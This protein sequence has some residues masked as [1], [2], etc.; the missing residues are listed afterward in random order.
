MDLAP[1]HGTLF[2]DFPFVFPFC[3]PLIGPKLLSCYLTLMNTL[4]AL[5]TYSFTK[6]EIYS[7]VRHREILSNVMSKACRVL[8]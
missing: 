8:E 6:K 2:L 7:E 1:F 5:L 3:V 4:I